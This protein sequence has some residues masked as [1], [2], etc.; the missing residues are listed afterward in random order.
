MII[1]ARVHPGETQSSFTLE[2]LLKF[3]LS[4]HPRAIALRKMYI[5]YIVP[6][7]NP[8]GVIMGN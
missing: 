7:L 6:M 8:D 1:T 2:G 5:L 4:D 3:L